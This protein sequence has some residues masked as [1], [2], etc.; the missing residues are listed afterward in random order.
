MSATKPL[1]MVDPADEAGGEVIF[2]SDGLAPV[3]VTKPPT[4]TQFAAADAATTTTTGDADDYLVLDSESISPQMAF[5]VFKG[6]VY[7]VSTGKRTTTTIPTHESPLEK[8]AR[9]QAEVTAL[10]Q[11]LQTT[12]ADSGRAFDEQV[13]KLATDLKTRLATASS[14]KVAEQDEL[15]RLIRQQRQSLQ[16]SDNSQKTSTTTDVP[17]TG[18]V[19]ELYGNAGTPTTSLEERLL[20]LERLLGSPQSQALLS[21]KGYSGGPNKSLLNRLEDME[22]LVAT[23][24]A[25]ALEQ[26]A[27]KAKVIR[28][29]LEAASKARNKLTATYKKEDSKMIQQL[30]QQM[31]D[32]EGLSGYLPS[33][34]DRLQQL[35]VLHRQS[36]TF[37]TRLEELERGATQV[38]VSVGQLETGMTKLQ[39][40]M[41]QNITTI[42]AN[43][44]KLDSMLK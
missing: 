5:E 17:G 31:V 32:L 2:S 41:V 34:V 37:G 3:Q 18:L 28:A 30:Y 35:S 9:L 11:E 6:K 10:E 39:E 40:T 7:S 25:T 44:E 15:T 27:T 13:V 22:A 26:T 42:E 19:Y 21:S 23:V 20:K 12:A 33:L 14:Q 8:L 43:L 24:D 1:S 4:V 16:S 38:E 29:D 36:A